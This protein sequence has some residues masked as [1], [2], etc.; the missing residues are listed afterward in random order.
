M[1][2]IQSNIV[3]LSEILGLDVTTKT[4]SGHYPTAR[5]VCYKFLKDKGMGTLEIA[6]Q[7]GQSREIIA[8]GL[9]KINDL[10][11]VNDAV[12]ANMWK[13]VNNAEFNFTR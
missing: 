8:G 10:L 12:A 6:E 7:F 2:N 1:D 9:R 5:F 4:R 11:S 3:Q 13:K